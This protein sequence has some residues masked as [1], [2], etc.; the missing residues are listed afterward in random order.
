MCKVWIS[1]SFR[2]A[3]SLERYFSK[4]VDLK[5]EVASG[6]DGHIL[7]KRVTTVLAKQGIGTFRY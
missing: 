5:L 1:G 3:S 7:A 2:G 6:E 4:I